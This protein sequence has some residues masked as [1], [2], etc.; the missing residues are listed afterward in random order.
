MYWIRAGISTTARDTL[1]HLQLIRRKYRPLGVN[2]PSYYDNEDSTHETRSESE[3]EYRRPCLHQENSDPYIG[4][5]R[6]F[7]VL[8]TLILNWELLVDGGS[9]PGRHNLTGRKPKTPFLARQLPSSICNLM[10]IIRNDTERRNPSATYLIRALKEL[11]NESKAR[12]PNLKIL[13]IVGMSI[14]NMYQLSG[15]MLVKDYQSAGIA[16]SFTAAG[17]TSDIDHSLQTWG[18]YNK[19]PWAPGILP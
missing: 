9:D 18:Y 4:S 1:E 12:L 6:N 10:L 19:A 5:L 16:L 17:N 15:S 7:N 11:L 8:K 2:D 3:Y 13:R 14:L